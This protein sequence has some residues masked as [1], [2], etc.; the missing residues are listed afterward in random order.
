MKNFEDVDPIYER[1]EIHTLDNYKLLLS[2]GAPLFRFPANSEIAFNLIYVLS[3]N[4]TQY[5]DLLLGDMI[6][7]LSAEYNYEQNDIKIVFDLW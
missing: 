4:K 5:Q 7:K 1:P 6:E 3:E 2:K